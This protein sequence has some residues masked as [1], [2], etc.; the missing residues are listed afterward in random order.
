MKLSPRVFTAVVLG[1]I[2]AAT[3]LVVVLAIGLG[4][5][6]GSSSSAP[7]GDPIQAT[8]ALTPQAALFGDT[9][10]AKVEVTF[11]R[12]QYRPEDMHVLA[13][14]EPWVKIGKP[15]VQRETAG[16]VTYLRTTY[17][18]R[19][20]GI[21]CPPTNGATRYEFKPARVVYERP[22]GD[23]TERLSIDAPWPALVLH[24]RLDAST[25][26]TERDTLAAPWRADYISL[27]AVTYRVSPGWLVIVFLLGGVALIA[28]GGV[29][30]YRAR[31]RRLPPP[32]PP[33]PPPAP[34]L[35][36]LEQA[37]AL[38]VTPAE[39][40][41]EEGIAERRRALELVADEVATWGGDPSVERNA[42]R[43]AWSEQ[44][45]AFED[46][47]ELAA[48]VRAHAA[49]ADAQEAEA[50]AREEADAQLV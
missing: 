41:D 40:G 8:A 38:L 1:G 45:P 20:L 30:A 22:A 19:C 44:D 29:L 49:E 18:L 42:R 4:R 28:V 17:T 39:R 9:V 34:R 11:D 37:L 25:S 47:K 27:P 13:S 7:G 35:A 16:P 26:P 3:A 6:T 15:V 2:G 36:P 31:P 14:F 12:T 24:T 5:G 23:T 46:M 32:P 50:R 21:R 33:P 43:L 10:T 48:S